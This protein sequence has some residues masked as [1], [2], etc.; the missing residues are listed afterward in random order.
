MIAFDLSRLL[1]RAGRGTPTGIDRVELAY[2]EHLMHRGGAVCFTAV[3]PS[4][5]LGLLQGRTPYKFVAAIGAAW[6]G[7]GDTK[8][9]DQKARTSARQARLALL[10]GSER[11][12][13]THLRDNAVSVPL[14]LLVSHHHLERRGLIERL[15][16]RSGARFV[17]LIHDLIPIEFPE[18]AKPG[19][20]ENH[21]RRIETAAQLADGLIVNSAGTGDS[22]APH[23]RRLGKATPVLV[24]PFGADLPSAAATGPAPFDRPYFV[25]V[26]T[27]EARKNHLLLLNLWR[28]LAREQGDRGPLLVLVGQRGWETENVIDML[29]RCP[30]VRDLVIEHNALP[31][32][33]MVRLMQG[34]CAVLLPSFAEGF[35]F[36]L[37]EALQLGVP[38]LCSDITTLRE[39]GGDVPEYFDPLDGPGWRS[40]IL[41]YARPG[42]SR[43]AAQL[44]RLSR[45]TAPRWD[46]HFA[47]VDR[48][49]SDIA[50]IPAAAQAI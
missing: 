27:I 47:M 35:G 41:D 12:L 5:R 45:W 50:A 39:T 6:R 49:L 46:T 38:V 17:C 20:A 4:G 33:E 36:P 40:A 16:Q 24:A 11:A 21:L 10:T 42:S 13:V 28:Q 23:V 37:V 8:R 14:Y 32:D 1:S 9:Y 29:E 25:Y 31:D 30:G 3:T 18:Y 2:A 19:Q 48:F 7:I 34:A 26:S 15:K 22:M 43:R 44:A